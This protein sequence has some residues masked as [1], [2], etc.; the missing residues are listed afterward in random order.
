MD[1]IRCFACFSVIAVH[2]FMNAG[3]PKQP[4]SGGR[5]YLMVYYRSF[6]MCCVPL[7]LM[8]S[9]Y[10]LCHKKPERRYYGRIGRL[11][12]VYCAASLFCLFGY[13]FLYTHLHGLL[14]LPAAD[15]QPIPLK[16]VVLQILGFTA[17]SYAW[18]VEMYL[19]LFL[20][21]PFL[22][23]L[24]AGIPSKRGKQL[25]LLSGVVLSFLPSVINVY[26]F[27][28][29]G[30]WGDPTLRTGSGE[31]YSFHP[32]IPGWWTWLYPVTYY[33]VGCYLREFRVRI[34]PR[35]CA[36]LILLTVA[37]SG[38]YCLWRTAGANY[39]AGAWNNWNS[40]FN[41]VLSLL[42][43]L[44]FLNLNC[45]RLPGAV[46]RILARL[47]ELCFGAYLVSWVWDK[48]FYPALAARQ[49][50]IFLRVHA[51]ILIV[52]GVFI[53]SMLTSWIIHLLYRLLQMT[54]ARL[55][56]LRGT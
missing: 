7:F 31:L 30:W 1:L 52:P 43:F 47:S 40:L 11:L 39:I 42:V 29:P 28:Q 20:M 15:F 53:C 32:L 25:L 33:F 23:I 41:L 6:F 3:F 14:G 51:W 34:R 56:K 49:P 21:I 55:R 48:L 9:G 54:G 37:A 17:D 2:F 18:Y 38:T 36:L 19:G 44:F 24:Y 22:N 35:T 5:M 16:S 12:F 26:N 4:V 27:N 10:L 46:Q 8:L 13:R 50:V 45:R